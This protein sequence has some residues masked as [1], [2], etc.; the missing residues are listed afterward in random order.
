MLTFDNFT[1]IN[2]VLPT[3][4]LPYDPKTGSVALSEATNIDI[5]L[6]GELRRRGGYSQLEE[7]C[8][9]NLWQ[10][11][12]FMLA[13]CDGDLTAIASDGTPTV[14]YPS[15]GVSRVHYCNLPDGRTTF[16]NSLINGITD[17]L[18]R[19]TWGVP[20]PGS[21]GAFSDVAGDLFPGEY[22]Y[23]LSYV[24]LA[25]GRE[26]G[27]LY[28]QPITIA[29]G[30]VFLSGL[31][32][33]EDHE[34][35]VY[36][37]SLEGDQVYQAGST[38]TGLFAFAGKNSALTLPCWTDQ[39]SPAPVGTI[40]AFWRGRV[41]LAQGTTLYASKPNRWEAFD[42]KRDFKQMADTITTLTPVDDGLYVGT[43]DGLYFLGGETWD[44]LQMRKVLSGLVVPGSAVAVRGDLIKLGDGLGSGS[45]MIC[46]ADGIL[47]AG[48]NQ[49]NTVR[50]TE[51]RYRTDAAEVAAT[52]R[53]LDGIPQYIAV[54]L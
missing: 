47:V 44:Q 51:G 17:G 7:T 19:T 11:D 3:E 33:L 23:A 12:G 41:V 6:S 53:V 54:P 15:L 18:V 52:F 26:G 48:F 35:V 13:T 42:L 38:M 24:R 34:I 40:T 8:H 27:V 28:S 14:I 2:N 31:P 21:L 25:D 37:S 10:A 20:I 16:S 45:A 50:L 9:K 22:R 29:D 49:G 32:V 36:L 39:E 5:G 43:D 30:G 1:G 46:I 4:R